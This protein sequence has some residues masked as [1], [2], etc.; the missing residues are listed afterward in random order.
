MISKRTS[1]KYIGILITVILIVCNCQVLLA[2]IND[3]FLFQGN[4]QYKAG[5][6]REAEEL[7]T[8]SYQQ[9]KSREAAYNLGNALYE[10]KNF[11]KA[12]KQFSDVTLQSKNTDLQAN[13]HF[14][15]G[16]TMLSEKKWE[17]AILH[18][19][20]SLKLNPGREDAKYNLAYALKQKQNQQNQ[21][22]K[23]QKNQ[24]EEKEK[25]QDP[26]DKEQESKGQS[27]EQENEKQ[28]NDSEENKPNN[29]QENNQPQ[30]KPQ[31]SKLSKEQ[32]E[33]L[34][35][36]LNQEEKKLKEKKD[37]IKGGS[38]QVDKDW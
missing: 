14:N 35:N 28:K 38:R 25:K 37:K 36:A 1:C 27:K 33:Q 3:Q 9:K 15:A 19:K 5:R 10:Q 16:N 2:Q 31:P 23:D 32:A 20:Q 24:P 4:Q 13:A 8:K 17:E 12:Y 11:E 30:P 6:Y 29:T 34:L 21:Q 22:N 26:L 18:Y 7:Y